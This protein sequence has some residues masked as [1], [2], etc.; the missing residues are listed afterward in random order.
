MR[1][2]KFVALGS[3][4]SRRGADAAIAEGRVR[5]NGLLSTAGQTIAEDD[6]VT[7]D[8]RPITPTVKTTIMFNKPV[9]YVCSRD[10]QGSR[11]IYDLLAPKYQHLNPVGRLDKDSS[12]LLL[13]TNDGELAQQLA[14]PS[15]QKQ[16]MYE[17]TLDKPLQPLH[18]QM[19]QDHGIQLEDGASQFQVER[20]TDG[21]DTKW[22]ITMYEGRNRQIRRTF[23]SLGY[24]V[25][26]LHRTHFGPY[27][28]NGVK[29]GLYKNL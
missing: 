8:D 5:V 15:Q 23:Q 19:I 9:G 4:L 3:G 17:I 6:Q 25:Q 24:S 29:P 21:D 2:N 18:R 20:I 11:T 28:L 1:V 10:G 14:H 13:L 7:L 26:V 16:K 27:S 22:R 12:G